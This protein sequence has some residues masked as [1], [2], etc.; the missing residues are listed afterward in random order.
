MPAQNFQHCYAVL[1]V[2]DDADR[3]T[4]RTAYKRLIRRWHPD[5]FQD[6]EQKDIAE[7]KTKDLNLAYQM[8]DE[9]YRENGRLPHELPMSNDSGHPASSISDMAHQDAQPTA[10]QDG[11]FS[12]RSQ[13]DENSDGPRRGRKRAVIAVFV[14]VAG[15][16][17]FE[18]ELNSTLNLFQN[19]PAPGGE[20]SPSAIDVETSLYRAQTK[21][22]GPD[23]EDVN[24]L[25][26]AS[27]ETRS[28]KIGAT[29][30]EVLAIQ[31]QPSRLTDT[32]W[33]YGLSRIDFHKGHVVGW[34]ESP[35]NPLRVDR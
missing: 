18:P 25:P 2:F 16:L 20:H 1:G 8:L 33:E 27:G 5:K 9:Y 6:P 29:Q 32:S 11:Q 24:T 3:E 35:M 23:T 19:D 12:P 15:Y 22:H 26:F 7:Q 4:V 28:I 10:G 14:I 13:E 21:T 30:K 17:L 34:F 31:G